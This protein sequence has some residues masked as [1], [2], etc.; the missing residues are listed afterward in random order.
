MP[1]NPQGLVAPP[2]MQRPPQMPPPPGYAVPGPRVGN[3]LA[4]TGFICGLF[5]LT[6]FWVG[7]ILCILAIVFSAIG[8][9]KAS[10]LGGVGKGFAIAGLVMGIVFLTPAACGL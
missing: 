2:M 3:P 4:L 9:S 8:M 10:R 7:F 6:P 5:G 1:A